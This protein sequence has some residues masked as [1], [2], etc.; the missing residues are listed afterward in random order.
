MRVFVT[1]GAGFIGSNLVHALLSGG[2]EVAIADDFSTGSP[3]NLDPRAISRTIDI[4]DPAFPAYMAEFAPDAVVHLAA[5]S[6][7]AASV[8]DPERDHAVNAGGTRAVAKAARE[9]GASRVLSASS[10]AVYGEPAEIP[11]GEDSPANPINPYGMSKLQAE[12]LLALELDGSGVDYASL[13]FANV[14]GPRQDAEGE[15]G[16]VAIFLS[17]VREGRAPVV[18]GTGKQTRDFIYVGDIVAALVTALAYEGSLASHG[19]A[20][21]IST[22]ERSS[23]EQLIGA[24]RL[25]AGYLGPVEN[26]APREGDIEHSALDPA[27]AARVLSWRAAVPL[28]TGIALTW[29]WVA[30]RA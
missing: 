2:H 19:A 16:V 8:R 13:R 7:V 9:A 17:R 5:Q 27:K 29:R 25:A 10:A 20:Y 28:E 1:G 26:E 22:G 14:Y 6:S 18:Y 3:A 4:L 11:L 12:S 21:N 30:S 24:V 23:V 15:G